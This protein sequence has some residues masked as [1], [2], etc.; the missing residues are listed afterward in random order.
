MSSVA[1]APPKAPRPADVMPELVRTVPVAHNVVDPPLWRR[2]SS[3]T[4]WQFWQPNCHHHIWVLAIDLDRDDALAHFFSVMTHHG[5]AAPSYVLERYESGHVQAGWFIERVSTGPRSRIKPQ[6]Y[7]VLVRRALTNAFGADTNF[8]NTRMRNPF[9]KGWHDENKG[10]VIWSPDLTPYKLGE[11]RT[12]LQ[13]ADVWNPY[14]EKT[15]TAEAVARAFMPV[16][17]IAS[18][19]FSRN[20]YIFDATRTRRSGEAADIAHDLNRSL[21]QPLPSSEV[22]TIVRSI[23]RY[24]S[25]HGKPVGSGV[26]S[27]ELR[28]VQAERG[29]KGGSRNTD[30]QQAV[31]A[32]ATRAASAVRSAK[33]VARQAEVL[34]LH[35]QGMTRRQIMA[36]LH[37]SE[38]TVKRAL[39]ASREGG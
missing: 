22:A 16:S 27:D 1:T 35:E 18:P 34:M 14:R 33:G 25:L 17:A 21:D 12:S 9:W 24:E 7:A 28:A 2:R 3:L 29:A 38:S 4:D 5:I 11:L 32:R 31:R 26:M 10:H 6:N 39:R 15:T 30:R 36:E 19:E 20:R 23:T 8:T 13:D 37:V